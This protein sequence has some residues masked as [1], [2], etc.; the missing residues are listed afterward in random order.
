MRG[1]TVKVVS[2]GAREKTLKG[3]K[4]QESYV[5]ILV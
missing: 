5:L 3:K 4:A 1:D 2:F